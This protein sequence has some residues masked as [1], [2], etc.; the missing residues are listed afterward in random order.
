MQAA[1]DPLSGEFFLHGLLPE[2]LH[3]GLESTLSS[4]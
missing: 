1:V 4:S 2:A 3:Q